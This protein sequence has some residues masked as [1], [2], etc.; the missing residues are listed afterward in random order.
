MH[1]LVYPIERWKLVSVPVP[2]RSNQTLAKSY[3]PHFEL[4]YDGVQ[5]TYLFPIDTWTEFEECI[6]FSCMKNFGFFPFCL[7][8]F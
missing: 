4:S 5:C 2:S 6:I 7:Y 1:G 8:S 3:G